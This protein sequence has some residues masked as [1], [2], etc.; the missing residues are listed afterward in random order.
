MKTVR[1]PGDQGYREV[2][3]EGS[4]V[5]LVPEAEGGNVHV[6]YAGGELSVVGF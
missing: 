3:V 5:I 2:V 1:L 6:G 4:T